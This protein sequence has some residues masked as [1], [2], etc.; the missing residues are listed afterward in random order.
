MWITGNFHKRHDGTW[1]S[2][3]ANAASRRIE[4]A[5]SV[6]A[7]LGEPDYALWIDGDA[8]GQE[9]L[10]APLCPKRVVLHQTCAR[11]ESA[12]GISVEF[13]EPHI[14]MSIQCQVI[15]AARQ[16]NR[17]SWMTGIGNR[18]RRQGVDL[19]APGCGEVVA[20]IIGILFGKP[21]CA[22]RGDLY[23]HHAI[24]TVRRHHLPK[25]LSVWIKDGQ[26]IQAHFPKPDTPLLVHRKP[27]HLTVGLWK[28]IFAKRSGWWG[29]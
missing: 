8:V 27:H 16:S 29:N 9:F 26:V 25:D 7:G 21:D 6:V 17:L 23:A 3:G 14:A 12:H 11:V 10:H 28:R 1:R 2:K 22:I 19:I 13:G 18:E 20:D 24:T 5:K 4:T 15:R